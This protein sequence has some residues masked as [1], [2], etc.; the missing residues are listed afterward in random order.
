MRTPWLVARSVALLL[1]CGVPALAQRT[2]RDPSAAG[3]EWLDR[4]R[5][6]R[7]NKW[8]NDR[9]RFCE[10]RE[11]RISAT[12]RLDIDGQQNG[13]VTV[14]GWDRSEV[15]VLAK[16]QTEGEDAGDARD[17][18]SRITIEIDAG[19][20]RADGPS[21]RRNQNWSVSYEV[22]T[23][24][25]TDI[26]ASTHN[27]GISVDNMDARLDLGAENGG[28]ALRGVSGDVHGETTNGPL[29]VELDGDRWRG[30]GLD[31]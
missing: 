8:S 24:R 19:R 4:C 18:A 31:L 23:P 11:K 5:E 22:W 9:E 15:Y 7:G 10:V 1:V 30:A 14:H 28:I 13:S 29:N 17:V 16:I 21:T 3:D 6:D 26:R 27:G 25:Q 12:R 20:V 2:P